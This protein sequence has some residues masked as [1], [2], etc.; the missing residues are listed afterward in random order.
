M[1]DTST[2]HQK[3]EIVPRH[4]DKLTPG[5][6]RKKNSWAEERAE[7]QHSVEGLHGRESQRLHLVRRNLEFAR[8]T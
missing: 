4:H 8:R 6:L 5:V 2:R 7:G 1:G 3:F